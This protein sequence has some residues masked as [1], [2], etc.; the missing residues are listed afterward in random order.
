LPEGYVGDSLTGV[1]D[2]VLRILKGYG[3][4]LRRAVVAIDYARQ[5]FYGDPKTL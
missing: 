4:F 2:Y 5:P 1:N 3:V